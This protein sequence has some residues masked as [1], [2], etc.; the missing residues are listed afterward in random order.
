[1]QPNLLAPFGIKAYISEEALKHINVS[2]I[3]LLGIEVSQFRFPDAP[4]IEDKSIVVLH[5]DDFKSSKPVEALTKLVDA[6]A[7][8]SVGLLSWF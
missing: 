3:E 6:T 8:V 5:V 2:A 4:R 1:L 7:N